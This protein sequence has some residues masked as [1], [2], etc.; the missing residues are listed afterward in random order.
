MHLE[1]GLSAQQIAVLAIVVVALAWLHGFWTARQ[2]SNAYVEA[3]WSFLSLHF[4]HRREAST[5][6]WMLRAAGL[7]LSLTSEAEQASI[8]D[9]VWR[10]AA[11]IAQSAGGLSS[12]IVLA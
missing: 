3:A 9:T 2:R 11:A 5:L 6:G 12:A 10:G 1:G 4:I 8:L 7:P